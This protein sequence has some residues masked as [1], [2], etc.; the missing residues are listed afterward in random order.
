MKQLFK[1][2]F[3]FGSRSVFYNWK[4]VF[5]LWGTN[6]ISAFI[7]SMP[8]Y[9]VVTENLSR[10]ILA[11]KVMGNFDYLWYLQ[12]RFLYEETIGEIPYMIYLTVGIYALAQTFFLGGLISVFNNPK[13]TH[14]VDFFYG[15][16]KYWY[17]F[18]RIMVISLFFFAFAFKIND[19]LGNLITLA[20][21]YTENDMADFILRSIRYLLLIFL[22]GTVTVISDYSKVAVCIND[23]S[24]IFREIFYAIKFIK[25][26]FNIVFVVFFLIAVMGASGAVLYNLII[27]YVSRSPF[28]FLL[29]SFILQQMLI[30]FRLLIRM[31]F[32][33][34][35]VHLYNELSA[36]IISLKG[37]EQ[38]QGV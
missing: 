33:A 7:L 8:V 1:Q 6:L 13:K 4:I 3:I 29:I 5:L 9:Y 22:I 21:S 30:I 16:V 38:P 37:K 28:Y 26:N 14:M 25:N 19:W 2:T 23:R 35:E 20:F 10:S 11:E 24:K 12:F 36:E 34:T 27:S 32:Y 15:G 17:R 18:T 31:L